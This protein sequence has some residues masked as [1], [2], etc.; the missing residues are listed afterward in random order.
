MRKWLLTFLSISFTTQAQASGGDVLGLL[1]FEAA[2][3]A[4]VLA[5]LFITKISLKNKIVIFGVYLVATA[6]SFVAMAGIPYSKNII[7][8]NTV[9]TVIPILAWSASLTYYLRNKSKSDEKT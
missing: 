9:S 8:I 3:F 7:L 4:L 1:W 2:L 6:C 5:S